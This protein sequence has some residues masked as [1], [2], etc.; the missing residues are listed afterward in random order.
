[1]STTAKKSVTTGPTKTEQYELA[2]HARLR[3]TYS[4]R[5]ADVETSDFAPDT[6]QHKALAEKR[7]RCAAKLGRFAEKLRQRGYTVPR[8]DSEPVPPA[9]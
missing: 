4:R 1:M 9:A 7:D 8:D 5:Y 3:Q 6:P 2:T